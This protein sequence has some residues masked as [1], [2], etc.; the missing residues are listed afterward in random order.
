MRLC[1]AMAKHSLTR[2]GRILL[3]A[4]KIAIVLCSS[5]L[6]VYGEVNSV[7]PSGVYVNTLLEECVSKCVSK[8][9][10]KYI[11]YAGRV[12]ICSLYL[13]ELNSEDGS[14]FEQKNNYVLRKDDFDKT[15]A[16]VVGLFY[17]YFYIVPEVY[18][19]D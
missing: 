15:H 14:V 18:Y 13:T 2:T 10:C 19:T 6:W 3:D 12:R 9:W 7:Q 17:N 11:G 16:K 1:K 5:F 4:V 8:P